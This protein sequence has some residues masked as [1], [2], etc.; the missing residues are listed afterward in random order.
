[1]K[2]G[3][4]HQ[5]HVRSFQQ[6]GIIGLGLHQVHLGI[7][8]RPVI[9]NGTGEGKRNLMADALVKNAAFEDALLDGLGNAAASSNGVDG[10]EVVPMSTA[11]RKTALQIYSEG[12]S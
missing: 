10:F 3:G 1:M 11:H 7:R 8:Q 5:D 4:E 9:A 12:G 6:A 2:H